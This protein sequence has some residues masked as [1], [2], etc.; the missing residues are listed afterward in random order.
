VVALLER[1][2]TSTVPAAPAVHFVTFIER[3]T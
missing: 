3:T 2:I 1:A